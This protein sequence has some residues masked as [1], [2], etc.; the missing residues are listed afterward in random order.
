[1]KMEFRYL[2]V[3]LA[4]PNQLNKMKKKFTE[5]GELREILKCS[6]LT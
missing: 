1:M 6:K 2:F 4:I 5:S 3:S